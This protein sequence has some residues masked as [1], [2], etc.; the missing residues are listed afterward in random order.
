MIIDLA[1]KKENLVYCGCEIEEV[2]GRYNLL[3]ASAE[4]TLNI[5][6]RNISCIVNNISIEDFVNERKEV[7]LTGG[8]PIQVYLVALHVVL[9]VFEVVKYVDGKGNEMRVAA[10]G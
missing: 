2:G 5:I 1:I 6:G 10:H 4:N 9:H 3:R 8:A 7:I